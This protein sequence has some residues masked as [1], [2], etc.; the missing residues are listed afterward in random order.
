[1]EIVVPLPSKL[2]PEASSQS[3]RHV[4]VLIGTLSFTWALPALQLTPPVTRAVPASQ[5]HV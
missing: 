2:F 1:M 4:V 3:P 5:V